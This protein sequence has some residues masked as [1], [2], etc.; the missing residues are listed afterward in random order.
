MDIEVDILINGEK[1][2]INLVQSTSLSL[3]EVMAKP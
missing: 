1:V 3:K 2:T